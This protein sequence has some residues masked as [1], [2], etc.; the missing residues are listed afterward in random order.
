MDLKLKKPKKP[1]L[2]GFVGFFKTHKIDIAISLFLFLFAFGIRVLPRQNLMQA[3]QEV[4][5]LETG[6]LMGFDSFWDARWSK[7]V[8]QGGWFPTHASMTNYPWGRKGNPTNLGFWLPN[9]LIY[10]AMGGPVEPFNY[11]LMGNIMSW[12]NVIYGALAVVFIYF[13]GKHLYSRTTGL[14]SGLFL[15]VMSANL[16]YSIFGHAENDAMGFMLFFLALTLFVLTVKKKSWKYGIATTL[17]LGWLALVWQAYNVVVL[18][19]GGTIGLYFIIYGAL[20]TFD[21]YKE[22]EDRR[23]MRKWMLYGC[24]FVLFSVLVEPII[25]MYPRISYGVNAILPVGLALLIGSIIELLVSGKRKSIFST[26]KKP[27]S[28][29]HGHAVEKGIILSLIFLIG[30][31]LILG[32][33]IINSPASSTGL[34]ISIGEEEASRFDSERGEEYS[35][36]ID[37]TIAEQKGYEGD[38]VERIG[39]LSNQQ[40]GLSIWLALTAAIILFAKLFIMPFVRKDFNYHWDIL[41]LAFIFG[42]LIMITKRAIGTFF[43]TSGVALGV[44]YFFGLSERMVKFVLK[45]KVNLYKYIVLVILALLMVF[46]IANAVTAVNTSKQYESGFYPE[47]QE[48]IHWIGSNETVEKNSVFTFWWDYGHWTNYYNEDK[49]FVTSDNIKDLPSSVYTTASSFTHTPECTEEKETDTVEGG[50]QL[51]RS[52]YTCETDQDALDEAEKESLSLLKPLHTDYIVIDKEIVLGK[53]GALTTIANKDAGMVQNFPCQRDEGM[54]TCFRPV[55]GDQYQAFVQWSEEEWQ[56]LIEE[57]TWPGIGVEIEEVESRVFPREDSQGPQ[58]FVPGTISNVQMGERSGRMFTPTS[59][60]PSL[61]S[62]SNRMFFRDESL[63]HLDLVYE[64]QWVMI[65][66]VKNKDEIPHPDEFTDFTK[67]RHDLP[68]QPEELPKK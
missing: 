64:N 61:Y 21:Y 66:E 27:R 55:E 32:P 48:A 40:F 63:K 17:A 6:G 12:M 49:V 20:K 4:P 9:A 62:L 19:I 60:T 68:P 59:N 41:A 1:S 26:F 2:S 53:W 29:L 52:E 28:L 67:K 38:L 46:F 33:T 37:Q 7:H 43:L 65:Y 57:T 18:L 36:R 8:A 31:G 54:M 24:I 51:F 13:L 35:S 3:D 30:G 14:S 16:F 5:E 34:D 39:T 58:L 25:V 50:A 15:S 47:W 56:E 45:N 44:G 42:L 11:G 22:S 10:R 23:K